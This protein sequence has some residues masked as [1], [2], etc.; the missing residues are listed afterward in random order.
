MVLV[1]CAKRRK[2]KSA[3]EA[4]K[5]QTS[6]TPVKT[7][8]K[9]AGN[10]PWINPVGFGLVWLEVRKKLL[11]MRSSHAPIRTL[12]LRVIPESHPNPSNCD[13]LSMFGFV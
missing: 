3:E 2:K 4:R 7:D 9:I 8:N 11:L 1:G 5:Q 6:T 12:F 10:V 13:N